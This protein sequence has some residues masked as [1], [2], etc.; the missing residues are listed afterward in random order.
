MK[1][2]LEFKINSIKSSLLN[3]N[4]II[5][6][7]FDGR[8]EEAD[9]VFF[10]G[11]I[12]WHSIYTLRTQAGGLICYVTGKDEADKMGIELMVDT[13]AENPRY[14]QLIKKPVYGDYPSFSL[15][16]NST[17][18]KTGINDYDRA[19]T[20]NELHKTILEKDPYEKF[21]KEFYSPGH[22]PIL[23]SRGINNRKGHT[24]L[25]TALAEYLGFPRS[26]VIA[27]M[28]DR[29]KSLSKEKALNFARENNLIFIEG[30]EI[31]E[32]L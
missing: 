27:E 25:V 6:Y 13:L 16:V 23:I 20:I 21:R 31:L 32:M 19:L 26:M 24:E 22:V 30:K 29:Q 18:V 8:E 12:D 14:S 3:G 10:A 9:M 7:D 2:I 4:P 17:K 11:S 15:W 1:N 5:V 28:L